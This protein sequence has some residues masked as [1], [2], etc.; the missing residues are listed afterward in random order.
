[1]TYSEYYE[2]Q[3][4]EDIEEMFEVLMDDSVWEWQF[5]H[6]AKVVDIS[7]R[8]DAYRYNEDG[9]LDFSYAPDYEAAADEARQALPSNYQTVWS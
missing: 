8:L 4:T 3:S 1:M 2:E 7:A 6:D 9:S 5:D